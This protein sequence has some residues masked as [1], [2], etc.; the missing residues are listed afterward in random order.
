M[1]RA[2][3]S[4]VIT[5]IPRNRQTYLSLQPLTERLSLEK[6]YDVYDITDVDIQEALCGYSEDEFE[7]VESLRVLKIL[8]SRFITLRK[9]F[10][11]CL[12][13]LGADGG[14]EDFVKWKAALDEIRELL[15]L[16]TDA[17][18]QIRCVLEQEEGKALS[19]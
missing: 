12:L 18:G 17:E 5:L 11:C 7:D 19:V 8:V 4:S 15:T 10:L 13:A 1:R 9:M 14:K 6:Y 2:L 16:A 3:F